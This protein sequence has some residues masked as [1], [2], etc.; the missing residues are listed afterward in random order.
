MKSP[1]RT[2]SALALLA[3]ASML[4]SACGGS[5]SPSA[6][7]P[8]GVVFTTD[9]AAGAET[10]FLSQNPATNDNR[11]VLDVRAREVTDLFGI[12]LELAYPRAVLRYASATEGGFLAGGGDFQTSLLVAER[13]QGE[14][15][16]GLT[17]LRNVRGRTG[18]GLLLTLEFTVPA[19]GTGSFEVLDGVAFARGAQQKPEVT[20]LGGTV[21]V[22]R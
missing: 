17:R 9:G 14:L 20:W 4:L 15:V 2:L 11:L 3:T 18:S 13:T 6:P 12:N 7:R 19:D 10:V 21:Q 22:N 5:S 1:A 8:A 16:I